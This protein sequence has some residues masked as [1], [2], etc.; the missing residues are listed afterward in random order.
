[1]QQTSLPGNLKPEYRGD[2]SHRYQGRFF[3]G[4]GRNLW[5][6]GMREFISGGEKPGTKAKKHG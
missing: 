6:D 1:M 5:V 4:T 3:K 2:T